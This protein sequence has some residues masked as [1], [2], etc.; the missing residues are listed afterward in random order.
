MNTNQSQVD[1]LLSIYQPHSS[2]WCCELLLCHIR[3]DSK[4]Q[5]EKKTKKKLQYMYFPDND[6]HLL[7][8]VFFSWPCAFAGN[9][10]EEEE[11]MMQEWF[12][13]VNKKNALIRRQNQLSL[14]YVHTHTHTVTDTHPSHKL[15]RVSS[16]LLTFFS[17]SVLIQTRSHVPLQPSIK[18]SAATE[19]LSLRPSVFPLPPT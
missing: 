17:V 12:M 14:L 2:D 19:P 8:L 6:H 10:K 11:A 7:T 9:N 16:L 13:L 1:F 15:L 5:I 4:L 18:L 3:P